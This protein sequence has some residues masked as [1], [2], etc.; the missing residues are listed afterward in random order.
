[1]WW[2]TYDIEDSEPK[3]SRRR[4]QP[5]W[6][7]RFFC[8]INTNRPTLSR[9]SAQSVRQLSAPINTQAP[10]NNNNNNYLPPPIENRNRPV[11]YPNTKSILPHNVGKKCLALDLDE[12][13]VHSSFQPV[14]QANYVIPVTIDGMVHNVFVIKRPGVDDFMKR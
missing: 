10:Q 13:L 11:K 2:Q 12:T 5:S 7:L 1:V 6:F 9:S 4:Q 3:D 14:P 8:C